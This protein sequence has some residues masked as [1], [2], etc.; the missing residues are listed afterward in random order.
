MSPSGHHTDVKDHS[1]TAGI[2]RR[3]DGWPNRDLNVGAIIALS[4]EL[5]ADKKAVYAAI[6]L[7]PGGGGNRQRRIGGALGAPSSP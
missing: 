4:P 2:G 3:R 6:W 5:T 7:L 1:I